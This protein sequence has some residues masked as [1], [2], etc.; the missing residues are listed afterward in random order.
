MEDCK[1]ET[2]PELGNALS[3]NSPVKR[4][5]TMYLQLHIVLFV[6]LYSFQDLIVR[7]P[8]CPVRLCNIWSVEK[9][10]GTLVADHQLFKPKYC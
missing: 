1:N 9:E 8:Q 5:Y 10:S 2:I 6:S 3:W 4:G 7:Y